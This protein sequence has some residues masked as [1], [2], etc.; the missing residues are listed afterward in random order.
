MSG[1]ARSLAGN[2]RGGLV[3]A[4]VIAASIGCNALS[5]AED[6]VVLPCEGTDCTPY[7]RRSSQDATDPKKGEASG[8]GAKGGGGEQGRTSSGGTSDEGGNGNGGGGGGGEDTAIACGETTC[9]ASSEVCCVGATAKAC[10]S[11]GDACV[12]LV[13]ECGGRSNCNSGEVCCLDAKAM[14]AEC[15]PE[16]SCG[17]GSG[18]F[19]FCRSD[20]DCPA[21][22]GCYATAGTLPE[23]NVCK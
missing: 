2:L 15:R 7:D 14:K 8:S 23:H 9:S 17:A 10:T 12:G 5:G 4:I 6:L 11:N 1:S 13:I 18:L 3:M 21:G 20:A 16:G 19:V 22:M